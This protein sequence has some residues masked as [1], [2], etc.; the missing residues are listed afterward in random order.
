MDAMRKTALVGGAFYLITFLASIPALALLDPV[1]HNTSFILGAGSET[2]VLWGTLLDVVNALACI[3]TAVALF[4][5]VKRRSEAF[6]L[7]FVTS[8]LLEAAIIMVGVVSL[9][10][11]VTLRHD[12]A[13]ATGPDASSLVTI[14]RS[15]VAVRGWTFLLGPSLM[16]AVNAVLLGTLMYRS[17]LVPRVIPLMG[18]VGAPLLLAST[19]ATLFGLHDQV[20]VTA[21]MAVLP[22]ALWEL[23]L[24]VWLTFMGFKPSPIT[25]GSTPTSAPSAF[26][27]AAA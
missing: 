27:H 24:G 10:A 7:G 15:L 19:V 16:A 9:L 4:P 11:V 13:G 17:G 6:A 26:S 14:G 2:R 12:L 22:V 25:A 3:G 20:S 1:L 8:R 5:V 18:L 21:T 23:S